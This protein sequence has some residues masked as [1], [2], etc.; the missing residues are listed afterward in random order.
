MALLSEKR[1]K[2]VAGD[3]LLII[4]KGGIWVALRKM[5][6]GE[7]GCLVDHGLIRKDGCIYGALEGRMMFGWLGSLF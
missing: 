3:D 1:L 6:I 4:L 7:R 2:I 5:G